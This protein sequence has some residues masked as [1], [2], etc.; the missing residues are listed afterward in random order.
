MQINKKDIILSIFSGIL[1]IA[2][3]PPFDLYPLAWVALVPLLI[4]LWEK[5]ARASFMLGG[6]TGFI[7]FLGTIYWVFNSMFNFGHVPAT[8]SALILIIL[9]VY[10]GAYIGLFAVIF[11]SLSNRSRFPSIVTVPVLWITLEVIRTYAFT[12]FPWSLLGY[13]QYKFLPII[14]ISDITGIYGV[15]FLVAATNGVIFDAAF[16]RPRRVNKMP[17]FP[18]RPITASIIACIIIILLTLGYGFLRLN[19]GMKGRTIRASVIQG[20]IDQGI[21]WD[22]Q[23]S[24]NI[25]N[26]YKKLSIRASAGAPD[27]IVW[28][29]SSFPFIYGYDE[30]PT[31]ELQ[32]FQ[33]NLHAS[34]LF[35]SVTAKNDKA[36]N[37]LLSNSAVL[38]SRE[39]KL[40]STYDKIHL[41]PYGEY[42]PLKKLFPF[43]N[44]LTAGIGDFVPGKEPV[45]MK[46]SFANI[47]NL[48]CYEIIF[49][50]LVRK[51]VNQGA[52]LL[53]TITNDAWFGRTS[54]PYQHFSMAVFRAVENRVPVVR[55]A[56]TGISGFID[57]KGR[58]KRKSD[59]FVE[60]VLSENVTIG[61]FGK[62]FYAKYGDLFAY[63]CIISSVLLIGNNFFHE[64]RVP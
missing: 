34:L 2:G 43:I 57:S 20:N 25:L 13:T 32:E 28:P 8:L 54:A 55:A 7:F 4:S 10:L 3:F 59:I 47:G 15:S 9:C 33:K 63:L 21:K 6:L 11:N 53:V 36:G 45:V 64:K 31:A 44:K 40:L 37:T 19:T 60:D 14:Q 49:P 42:I 17:L 48:I 22:K 56:N 61:A 1:L 5:E 29:E 62:S 30:K 46:A 50:G 35:G 27:I 52:D 23:H 39:G 16:H 24:E 38:L 26:T 41:V 51:F 18:E 12:G 58:I